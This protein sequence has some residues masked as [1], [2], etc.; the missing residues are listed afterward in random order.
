MSDLNPA[1][2]QAIEAKHRQL[3]DRADYLRNLN[4]PWWYKGSACLAALMWVTFVAILIMMVSGNVEQDT[5]NNVT[6]LLVMILALAASSMSQT[7]R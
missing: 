1:K 6:A 5:A 7:K 3:Q 2:A 4:P